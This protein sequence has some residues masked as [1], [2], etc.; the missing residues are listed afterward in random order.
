MHPL[1][2]E[3]NTKVLVFQDDLPKCEHY[4][5]E[6]LDVISLNLIRG[7]AKSSAYC[8]KDGWNMLSFEL[9]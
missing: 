1:Q 8:F 5:Q 9:K 3:G 6:D 2:G 7:L 4:E